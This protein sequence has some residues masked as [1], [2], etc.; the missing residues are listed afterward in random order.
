MESLWQD[1]LERWYEK[2]MKKHDGNIN[3][4]LFKIS[5]RHS[6]DTN[7][8]FLQFQQQQEEKKKTEEDA[9]NDPATLEAI[10]KMRETND[11]IKKTLTDI[12]FS[13]QDKAW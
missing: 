5:K 2:E 1:T 3:P 13:K 11:K 12:E 9:F 10:E 8:K 6:E 4:L 7:Q